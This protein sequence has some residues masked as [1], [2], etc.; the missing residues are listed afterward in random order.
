MHLKINY[1]YFISRI[2][3]T[4]TSVTWTTHLAYMRGR[5]Y[6]YISIR[7]VHKC[8]VNWRFILSTYISV[9]LFSWIQTLELFRFP[10]AWLLILGH[11]LVNCKF[12]LKMFVSHIHVNVAWQPCFWWKMLH[13][14]QCSFSLH[15][16]SILSYSLM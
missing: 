2:T 14:V 9:T 10:L 12:S 7:N 8:K 1:L 15:F 11:M 6:E 4:H 13:A 5:R 3:F 16:H